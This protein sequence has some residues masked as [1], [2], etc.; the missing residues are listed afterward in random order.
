[1]QPFPFFA[2]PVELRSHILMFAFSYDNDLYQKAADEVTVNTDLLTANSQLYNEALPMFYRCNTFLVH[3][4]EGYESLQSW[5]LHPSDNLAL[6]RSVRVHISSWDKSYRLWQ[7]DEGQ[8]PPVVRTLKLCHQLHV[9]KLTIIHKPLGRK[10]R[11]RALRMN[12]SPPNL[13]PPN[14]DDIMQA[15]ETIPGTRD[16][17]V[18]RDDWLGIASHYRKALDDAAKMK[19]K[20]EDQTGTLRNVAR[21]NGKQREND[22]LPSFCE[23]TSLIAEI[24]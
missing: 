12:A 23:T 16:I 22:Q 10:A 6:I 7:S 11:M 20:I 3:I 18:L 24:R 13:D 2:L 9:L 4:Y 8:I 1:M 5:V 19:Q 14:L 17:V 15:F 21:S